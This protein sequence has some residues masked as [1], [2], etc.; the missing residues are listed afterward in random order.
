VKIL[1]KYDYNH[2]IYQGQP[3][4]DCYQ[5]S[6]VIHPEVMIMHHKEPNDERQETRKVLQSGIAENII[7]DLAVMVLIE[8]HT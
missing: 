7:R 2:T 4:Y 3:A 1:W 8:F 6:P 5:N